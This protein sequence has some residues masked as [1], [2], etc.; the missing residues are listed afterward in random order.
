MIKYLVNCT[1]YFLED[2]FV[3]VTKKTAIVVRVCTKSLMFS[4]KNVPKESR[5]V[6]TGQNVV[7]RS[8]SSSCFFKGFHYLYIFQQ[9]EPKTFSG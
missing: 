2:N 3:K 6:I 5:I 9:S 8:F 1:W 7:R 4:C